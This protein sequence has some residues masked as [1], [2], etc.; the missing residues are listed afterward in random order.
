MVDEWLCGLFVN[1]V[2]GS[3]WPRS[4]KLMLFC[5]DE[6]I[7]D[8]VNG[9]GREERTGGFYGCF[10]CGFSCG[11]FSVCCGLFVVTKAVKVSDCERVW[12]Q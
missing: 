8:M 1:E 3:W 12:L 7:T 5:R 11:Y 2:I 10:L 9:R 4:S 6:S